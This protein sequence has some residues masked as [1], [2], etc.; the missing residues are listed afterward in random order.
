MLI[1]SFGRSLIF[2]FQSFWRNFWLSLA[3]IVIIF[4]TFL[5]INFLIGIN[6]VSDSALAAVKDR[7]DISVYFKP[8]VPEA[9]ISEIKSHLGS[10]AQV[11]EIIYKSPEQNLKEF[12]DRHKND[13]NIQETLKELEGNP[14]GGTLIIRAGQLS[15]YPEILKAV[16][17]PAYTDLIEEKNYE[18]HQLVISRINDISDNVRKGAILISILFVLI[19]IL[20]VFNTVRIAIFTHQNE[21]SI[22]KLV[23]ASNWFI[24]A[25]FILE[26]I[27]SGIIGCLL[28]LA[29]VY[30]LLS[31][32]Q[33][34]LSSFFNG[35][36][37]DLI[38]YFNGHFIW[39]VGGQ[40]VGIIL[41]NFISSGAA[42][43][44]YLKV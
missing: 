2:A 14:L 26:S 27:F 23:G 40:L 34:Q 20:I 41:L 32:I 29:V 38:G 15:E 35:A 24:R 3:T 17:N 31:L 16:D 6:A 9:K 1:L 37:F 18:D 28:A 22:M 33:P 43:S 13:A 12:Q 42:I 39:I 25:P 7:V 36:N 5:S 19:A 44:R 11:K 30:P 4:L 21:I 8:E 10:M